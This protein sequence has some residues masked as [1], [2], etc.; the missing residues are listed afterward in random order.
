[1][2]VD[3][4]ERVIAAGDAVLIPGG[5]VQWIENVGSDILRFVALVSPPWSAATDAR[6]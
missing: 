3:D 2:H 4:E 6:L 5:A 1:M